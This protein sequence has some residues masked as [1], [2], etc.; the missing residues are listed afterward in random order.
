MGKKVIH[1]GLI[2]KGTLG[3]GAGDDLLTINSTTGEVKKITG[4]P[5][6]T[7]LTSGFLF[8]GNTSNVATATAVTGDVL[9]SNTGVTSIATGVIVNADINA[10]A[11]IALTK[12]AASTALRVP[13][14]GAGGFFEPSSVTNT[15]LSYLSGVSSNIQTQFSAKQDTITGGASTIATS[16]LGANFALVSNGSGKVIVSATTSTEIGYSSGVTSAIQTQ[17]DGK[18][19]ATLT[20]EAEGDTIIRSSGVWVNLPAGSDGQ[21]FTMDAGLPSWQ[22]G[23]SNG[24][25]SG[26]TAGQLIFKDSG[27]DYDVNWASPT[28]ATTAPDVTA[29][30]DDLNLLQGLTG[31]ITG[32][33]LGYLA[34]VTSN[35]NTQFGNKRDNDL[36]HNAIWRGSAGNVAEAYSAGTE[37]YV[38]MVVSGVPTW[39]LPTPPGDVSGVGPSVDN[40]IAR[41][42][43][44]AADSIQNSGIII[45]D[46]DNIT[47]VASLRTLN[48]GGILLRELTASGT[49][50]ITLRANGTM[51]SDYTLTFPAAAPGSN[52]Y[53]KYDGTN[54]VWAS[55]GG[56]GAGLAQKEETGTTYTITDADDGYIIYFTNVAGCTVTLPNTISTDVSWTSVQADGAGNVLHITSG[57]AVLFTINGEV[58]I[59]T[60]N[61]SAT[62]VKKTATDFYGWGALGP[63]GGSGTVIT[64]NVTIEGDGSVGD[65]VKIKTGYLG[66]AAL[67]DTTAFDAA[68]SASTAQ[69]AAIASSAASL[70]T[71]TG[72][73]SNPHS[74]TKTQVGLGNVDNTSDV[75]KPVSTAQAAAITAATPDATDTVKGLS[76]LYTTTVGSNTDGAPSQFAVNSAIGGIQQDQETLKIYKMSNFG[77]P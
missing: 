38:L 15:E 5:I 76:K 40:A 21:V 63:A 53:L 55:A 36:P 74:V 32:T 58:D 10:S 30:F 6:T 1:N 31:V 54:Y 3:S 47:G 37:G 11:A 56:G 29:T 57:G 49:N 4:T 69:A 46:S 20:A 67:E 34:G 64:D 65:P 73:T 25:P 2:I 72:N 60:E 61:G 16:N 66:S 17:L 19:S 70:A 39:A 8:V 71:H 44:V 28:L 9:I 7:T 52:T 45:D 77:T 18:L 22:N 24:I 27:T 13:Q 48:Q 59:E 68:G 26:G 14:F 43:G 62:W 23:T 42:N 41:W 50:A 35:I 33:E 51:A 75:N 12:L